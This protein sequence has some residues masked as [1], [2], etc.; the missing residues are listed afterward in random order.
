MVFTPEA[1]ADAVSAMK[2]VADPVT[3]ADRITI[4]AA[5]H[6]LYGQQT[7]LNVDF[8][9]AFDPTAITDPA[10]K[11]L[12]AQA[13]AIMPF[14]DGKLNTEK[15]KRAVEIAQS[16]GIHEQFVQVLMELAN[17][18]LHAVIGCMIRE[19]MISLNDGPMPDEDTM[20]FFLP[21][22]DKPDPAFAARH[23][24]LAQLPVGT[25]GREY[26]AFYK[27]NQFAFP[28]EPNGLCIE[29]A[30]PHDTTHLLSGYDTDPHGEL[31][32][33]TFTAGM[34]PLN[35]IEGHILPVIFS[36]HLGIKLND[37]AKS[38]TG[39]FDP[40]DFWKAWSRGRQVTTDVF[41]KDWDFWSA[42]ERPLTELREEYGVPPE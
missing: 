4:Q 35:P 41:Q 25:L 9:P 7:P 1:A 39:A 6:Y 42:C 10:Q 26:H 13:C 2:Q 28:G 33:S 40:K 30:H 21:Y 19:N 16:L 3:D 29:F 32:V 31:L 17:H 18:H 20:Q 22:R 15:E 14:V 38:T 24:A 8:L 23:E 5:W 34:H 12:I 27:R 37:I 36:W 11:E